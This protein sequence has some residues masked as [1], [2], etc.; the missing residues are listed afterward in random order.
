MPKHVR[1][2]V[3]MFWDRAEPDGTRCVVCDDQC[4]LCMWTPVFVAR[5]MARI[6]RTDIAMCDS[7]HQALMEISS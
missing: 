2:N 5:K 6:K 7:C 3:R 1:I 4:F